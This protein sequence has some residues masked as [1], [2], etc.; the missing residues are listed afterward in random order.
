MCD[1]EHLEQ[2]IQQLLPKDVIILLPG[3]GNALFSP[4]MYDAGYKSI[5]NTDVSPVVINQQRER[6]PDMVWEVMDCLD[7][8]VEDDQYFGIVDKSLIDTILCAENR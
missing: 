6:Y 3:C 1:Y 5:V 2:S 8:S 7:M 4:D